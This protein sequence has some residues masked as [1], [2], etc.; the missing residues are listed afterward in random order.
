[1]AMTEASKIR[2]SWTSQQR[3]V[4]WL[5]ESLPGLPGLWSTTI[6]MHTYGIF[7]KWPTWFI[8]LRDPP[9]PELFWWFAHNS[10]VASRQRC[11][12]MELPSWQYRQYMIPYYD[13]LTPIN[14]LWKLWEDGDWC[15][16]H[17]VYCFRERYREAPE[18][19]SVITAKFKAK[20]SLDSSGPSLSLSLSLSGCLHSSAGI[21]L[22]KSCTRWSHL[23]HVWNL[24]HQIYRCP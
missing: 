13:F 22:L 1:M 24:M 6:K 20:T 9:N 7:H 16:L 15:W 18:P 21:S 11:S 4:W 5:L 8:S 14:M 19:W 2:A 12:P 23:L 3:L 17:A 10:L